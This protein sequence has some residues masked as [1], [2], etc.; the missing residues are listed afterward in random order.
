MATTQPKGKA[1]KQQ[2]QIKELKGSFVKFLYVLWN[3]LKLPQ[4]TRIQ[5]DIAQSLEA[6]GKDERYIIQAFRGIGKSFV[7]CAFVVW[8]LWNNPDLKIMIVS[9][10][11]DRADANSV[12]I[13]QIIELLP[14]LHEL[15]ADSSKGQRDSKLI[16]DVGPAKPDASPSVKSV[17]ITGQLTGSRAD[18]LIADDVEVPN[19]S[20]TSTTREKLWESVKEFDSI[21]KPGGMIIYLGTPQSEMTLYKELEN[22][23]YHTN[24]WPC[25][26]PRNYQELEQYGDRLASIIRND[27][28]EQGHE[29]LFWLPTD[30]VRFDNEDLVKREISYGKAGFAMQF[31]LNPNLSDEAKYPLKLKNLI[32]ADVERDKSPLT[33]KWLPNPDKV[34]KDLPMVGLKGDNYYLYAGSSEQFHE[35]TSRILVIDPSGRGKD[36]TAYAVLYWNNGY[37]YLMDIGGFNDG[38]GDSTLDS[39]ANI[40]KQHKVNKVCIESNFGDGMFNKL[41]MPVVNKI[42]ATELVEIRSNKQKEV[43]ICDTLEP[44]L[45]AH[46]L[47]ATPEVITKDYQSSKDKDGKHSII[48]CLMYQ[49]T[50]ISRDKGALKHDDRLDVLAMGVAQFTEMMAID[51]QENMDYLMEE[52]LIDH[53]ERSMKTTL[54]TAYKSVGGDI[55]I[56]WEDDD[57]WCNSNIL[58]GRNDDWV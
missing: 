42:H 17:G 37:I 26:Y 41:L 3:Q 4:P 51:A 50:R 11:K 34:M 43:R 22:R 32:I 55:T 31:M 46:K 54:S 33:W 10:S 7:T 20:G 18:I 25:R 13:K 29:A 1:S 47:I 16:F 14:F 9:A 23:G 49:L 56:S 35:Y 39:L 45:G 2:Q 15:K 30:P 19:N 21:L 6:C 12:F 36:T 5:I 52:F 8:K 28:E 40:A 44:V 38:Y 48:H 24:I 57:D 58:N 53:L 27:M